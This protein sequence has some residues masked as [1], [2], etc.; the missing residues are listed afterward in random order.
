MTTTVS[1]M[2]S[3]IKTHFEDDTDENIRVWEVTGRIV[4]LDRIM[5]SLP[6]GEENWFSVLDVIKSVVVARFHTRIPEN[7]KDKVLLP[8][9]TLK[10]GNL[11]MFDL[12]SVDVEAILERLA[13]GDETPYATFVSGVYAC[14]VPC[15]RV[16]LPLL[17]Q[18]RG[19]E[20]KFDRSR[21][22]LIETWKR[23]RKTGHMKGH[24]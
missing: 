14:K 23:D 7:K 10:T 5:P 8:N 2:V 18:L 11:V 15:V 17:E 4:S 3:V 1:T 24:V 12:K 21:E 19:P 16:P 13:V 6:T 22:A 9:V 20:K